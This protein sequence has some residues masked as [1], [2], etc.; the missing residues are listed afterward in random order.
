MT[1]LSSLPVAADALVALRMAE[2]EIVPV[3]AANNRGTAALRAA[4]LEGAERYLTAAM[5]SARMKTARL[6]RLPVETFR[7]LVCRGSAGPAVSCTS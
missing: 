5:L 3:V 2:P 6:T 7:G 1:A 4:D